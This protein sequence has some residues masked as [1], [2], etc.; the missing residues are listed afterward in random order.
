MIARGY[1]DRAFFA[2]LVLLA[3][4]FHF[5]HEEMLR[6]R[7]D[8]L[9]GVHENL[10]VAD[11]RRAEEDVGRVPLFNRKLDK[12]DG[13]GEMKELVTVE[14]FAFD[15][16]ERVAIRRRSVQHHRRFLSGAKGVSVSDYFETAVTIAQLGRRVRRYPHCRL[17]PDR[18]GAFVRTAP[19]DAV[20]TF[21]LRREVELCLALG[22]G[23]H[24]LSE[25]VITLIA[26]EFQSP[27]GAAPRGQWRKGSFFAQLF[28]FGALHF[29]TARIEPDFRPGIARN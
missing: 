1:G 8:D 5:D 21:A 4:G 16:E 7:N 6:G 10:S 25:D 13:S 18:R 24:R 23:L 12:L 14:I 20:I 26:A 11:H 29:S 2:R 19:R 27:P 28:Q 3:V 15:A 17:R 9:F 22:V